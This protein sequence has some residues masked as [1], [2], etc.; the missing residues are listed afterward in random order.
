MAPLLWSQAVTGQTTIGNVVCSNTNVEDVPVGADLSDGTTYR[1]PGTTH[2]LGAGRYFVNS[3]IQVS[4]SSPICYIGSSAGA[5]EIQLGADLQLAQA[6]QLAFQALTVTGP[7]GSIFP[8]DRAKLA[9]DSVVFRDFAGVTIAASD[10]ATVALTNV[11][12]SG[13]GLG[14]TAVSL[15]RVG[16][17]T[18]SNVT[19]SDNKGTALSLDSSTSLTITG[20]ARFLRNGGSAVATTSSKLT[21][22]DAEFIGNRVGGNGGAMDLD[23]AAE[24]TV[25]GSLLVK[26]NS[27]GGNGGGVSAGCNGRTTGARLILQGPS[28]FTGNSAAGNGGAVFLLDGSKLSVEGAAR[29]SQ[30]TAGVSGGAI[31]MTGT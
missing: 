3:P 30:N 26:D 7:G 15:A 2:R 6:A 12:V 23:A 17:P 5:T 31:Y 22:E 28:V 4:D 10:D 24:V 14:A 27:A 25:T 18:W 1:T 9:A 8:S 21:L 16:N 11:R 19:F 13:S 20:I 29:L